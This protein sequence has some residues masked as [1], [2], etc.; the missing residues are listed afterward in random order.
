MSAVPRP[1]ARKVP[2]A[3]S[4]DRRFYGVVEAIVVEVVD[5]KKEGRIKIRFPW[6]DDDMVTEWCRVRQMYAG[7]GYGCFFIPEKGDEVLVAFIHGDMRL[8]V[9]V[10]G[11]YNG[12]DKPPSDRQDDKDHKMIR[13][14]GEHE[15]LLDDSPNAKKVRIK[16]AGKH[17]F[18]LDDQEKKATVQT[19]GGHSVVMDD[20]AKSLTAKTSGG[21]TL[22]MDDTGQKVTL[23]TSGGQMVVLD[24]S[25]SM[26]TIQATNVAISATSVA[27]QAGTVELGNGASEPVIL[28]TTFST[29]FATHV[30]TTTL[31]GLPTSPPVVPMPPNCLSTKVVSG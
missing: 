7:P 30:H 20:Q 9:I 25:S 3:R 15:V 19:A 11:L 8:P 27:V 29:Y 18:N 10:G 31:P 22:S 23:Q 13:T 24:M 5:P 26:I 6:F 4:T 2:R 17:L 28:G 16:T 12:K 1:V 14:K 21:H